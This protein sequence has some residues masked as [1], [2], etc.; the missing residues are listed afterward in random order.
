MDLRIVCPVVNHNMLV[1][2]ELSEELVAG[3]TERELL[4]KRFIFR[5]M[6]CLFVYESSVPDHVH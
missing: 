1:L 2:E 4:V 5:D 6:G 3:Q